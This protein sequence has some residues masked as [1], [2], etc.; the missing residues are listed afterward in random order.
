M[1]RIDRWWPFD[2]LAFADAEARLTDRQSLARIRLLNY[3]WP[4][5]CLLPLES[6]A[7]SRIARAPSS[8]WLAVL[9]E[10]TRTDLGWLHEG[11]LAEAG[12]AQNLARQRAEAG[13]RSAEKRATTVQRPFN[14]RSTV[15]S[16]S[17]VSVS[18]P[19]SSVVSEPSERGS[20]SKEDS[21]EVSVGKSMA[22]VVPLRSE[23]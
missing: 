10:F 13:K 6:D 22:K 15:A 8:V 12:K 11:M 7:I 2:R 18:V 9:G 3:A 1:S 17:R 23:A 19:V 20:A 16:A 21:R 5:G 4:N 14:D